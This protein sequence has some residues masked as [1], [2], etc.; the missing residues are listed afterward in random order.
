MNLHGGGRTHDAVGDAV[1]HV[2]HPAVVQAACL[3]RSRASVYFSVEISFLFSV[4][5]DVEMFACPP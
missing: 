4:L 5:L 3:H 2:V 1:F